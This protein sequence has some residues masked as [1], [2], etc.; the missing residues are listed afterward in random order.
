M[1][2]LTASRGG[3]TLG[4]WFIENR[5]ITIGRAEGADIRLEDAAVSKAHAAIEVRGVDH[6][7]LDLES[8]NGTFVNGNRVTRHLLHH[9]DTIEI[10]DFQIRYV[11]HKSVVAA[12]GDRTMIFRATDAGLVPLAGKAPTTEAR[13][14]EIPLPV[15]ALRVVS[16]K[17][18]GATVGLE[19]PL[20][21]VGERARDYCAILR[22]PEGYSLAR[23]AGRAPRLD[24][25]P[26]A[27]GW[28]TLRDGATIEVGGEKYELRFIGKGAAKA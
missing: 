7:L 16:G 20:T 23:V 12:E 17:Q 2:K 26:I 5:R 25:K 14:V 19:R 4:S 15:A 8:A 13:S 21:G 6:M 10:L 3:A 28:Q 9:G 22:R 11:D 24:G 27:D 1:A 18:A